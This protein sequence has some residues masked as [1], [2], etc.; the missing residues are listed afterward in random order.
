M[1]LF[2]KCIINGVECDVK[3][4]YSKEGLYNWLS[5]RNIKGLSPY[6]YNEFF[7]S[8]VKTVTIDGFTLNISELY[9]DSL[10]NI[11]G[12]VKL[13]HGITTIFEKKLNSITA[14]EIEV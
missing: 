13:N 2:V 14:L 5:R 9:F 12:G 4:F 8:N 7:I 1:K 10:E 3:E 11:N 6:E